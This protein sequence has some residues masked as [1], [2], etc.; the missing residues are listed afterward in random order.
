M[1]KQRLLIMLSVI[2]IGALI[3]TG[4]KKSVGTPEDNATKE[5]A[6]KDAEEE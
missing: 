3:F 2:M 4:C 1:R 6:K 5:E